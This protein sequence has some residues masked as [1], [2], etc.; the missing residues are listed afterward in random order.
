MREDDTGADSKYGMDIH[1]YRAQQN[2]DGRKA[3]NLKRKIKDLKSRQA[4]RIAKEGKNQHAISGKSG[5]VVLLEEALQ[6][7]LGSRSGGCGNGYAKATCESVGGSTMSLLIAPF[8]CCDLLGLVCGKTKKTLEEGGPAATL[9]IGPADADTA[10]VVGGSV[11]VFPTSVPDDAL[12]PSPVN[13]TAAAGRL[14][15]SGM[16]IK[17]AFGA[18][19]IHTSCGAKLTGVVSR[20]VQVIGADDG[21]VEQPAPAP[22][23]GH[24]NGK[25][26][27]A[28]GAGAKGKSA[29]GAGSTAEA[30]APCDSGKASSSVSA[31]W[32]DS[33]ITKHSIKIAIIRVENTPIGVQPASR[34][35]PVNKALPA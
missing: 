35:A 19:G 14:E 13:T 29:G 9:S 28:G 8:T 27:G 6:V 18:V 16:R 22:T 4:S 7:E 26:I 1:T 21:E 33:Y 5:D 11:K 20:S 17:A 32:S 30:K 23:K 31:C 12:K 24:V 25:I 2:A 15:F 10:A 34:A 3:V